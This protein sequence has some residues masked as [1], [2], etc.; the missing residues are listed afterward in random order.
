MCMMQFK[1]KSLQ[2]VEKQEGFILVGFYI[3]L[4]LQVVDI[5]IYY[6][7]IVLVGKDQEQYLEL[8]CNIVQCF[9]NEIGKEYFMLFELLYIEVFKVMLIVDL[10]C[11]M[12]VSFGEKYNID[13]FVEFQWI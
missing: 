2:S 12:S 11:K 3:Y 6:V 5:L 4:V 8:M 1:D 7:I 9:N 13:V 10:S